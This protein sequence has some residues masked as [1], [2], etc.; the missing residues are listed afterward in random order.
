MTKIH[1]ELW[2]GRVSELIV[3]LEERTVKGEITLVLR[4]DQGPQPEE[5]EWNEP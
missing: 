3:A 2:S 5:Q 4:P 1:E